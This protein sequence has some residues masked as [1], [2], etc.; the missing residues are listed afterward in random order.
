MEQEKW[1]HADRHGHNFFG[2]KQN[3]RVSSTEKGGESHDLECMHGHELFKE[4]NYS[5][6]V[7][8]AWDLETGESGRYEAENRGPG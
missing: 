7:R 4:K 1:Y 8:E 2:L 3:G 5:P 6:K